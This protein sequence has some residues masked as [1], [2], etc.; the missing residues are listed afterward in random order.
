M[1]LSDIFK[2]ITCISMYC[3]ICIPHVQ[4]QITPDK[5]LPNNSAVISDGN[6]LTING[7]TTAGTNLF[8]SFREFSLLKNQTAIFNNS[9]VTNILT[10][11]TGNEISNI[12]GLIQVNDNANLFLLNPAGIIFG[13][14]AKLNIGGSF[15]ASTA[16]SIKFAD[17]NEFSAINPQ[18][19]SLLTISVPIGLQFGVNPGKIINQ[20]Q[21]VSSF[22]LPALDPRIPISANVGLQV[23]PG[24]TLAFVGGDILLEGGNLT[25]G[26]GQIVVVSLKSE[27]FVGLNLSPQGLSLNYSDTQNLGEVQLFNALINTTGTG[28][29][30]VDI[31]SGNL[32]LD[33]SRILALT[34]ADIDGKSVDIH[35]K[36]LHLR[37]GSQISTLT[38]GEGKGGNLNIQATDSAQ[39]NGIGFE[40]FQ[41]A[42]GVYIASGLL[43]PFDPTIVLMTG[44]SGAGNAGNLNIDTANFLMSEGA[45]ILSGTL[46]A[47]KSGNL[48]IRA[49]NFEVVGAG[50]NAGSYGG[51]TGKGGD[52][53]INTERFLLRDGGAIG[54]ETRT[55]QASGNI[56]IQGT[57]SVEMLNSLSEAVLATI[58]VSSTSGGNGQ[59]GGINID[60]KRFVI[61]GG[62][63]INSDSGATV[64]PGQRI[65]VGGKGGDITI[66]ASESVDVRG[67]SGIVLSGNRFS[68]VIASQTLTPSSGGDIQIFT[69]TL[70]V[71]D[72]GA[73]STASLLGLGDAGNI[74][75]IANQVEVFGSAF[76][77]QF[78]SR[79]DAS[80]GSR[81]DFPRE[82]LTGNGGSL[83]LNV[84]QLIVKDGAVINVENL[85]LG[86]AGNINIVA[87]TI[88]LQNK[89]A[90]N[91][92]TGSGAGGN[93]N[94][95][96][97]NLLLR[98]QSRIATDAGSSV[99]GN[100]KINT[101]NLVAVENS[102][103]TAN[104]TDS[105]GGN[106][107]VNTTGIIGTTFREQLSADSDITATGKTSELR[108]N[109]EINTP[110][111]NPNGAT[112][113]LPSNLV[114]RANQIA[115]TCSS[116]ARTNSFITAGRGGVSPTPREV[117]NINSS[118][119]DWR[120]GKR[121]G[122]KTEPQSD[123]N[124]VSPSQPPHLI[125]AAT[126]VV[127]VDGN[128]ALI[129]NKNTRLN[130]IN[131]NTQTCKI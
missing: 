112:V 53:H 78:I 36:Q 109:V 52:I 94:L 100:I 33:N 119:M 15:I 13:A 47:G 65:T 2:R 123:S 11:V 103:I 89:G 124:T 80:V 62:A 17:G 29:G 117:V 67:F 128:V 102:D 5:T 68:T 130:T 129:A 118:W 38:L 96:A 64:A 54:S 9:P 45:V 19:P 28:G 6:I 40:K 18:T 39:I 104:S 111:I 60:T 82:K 20:S 58:I 48:T 61:A 125:E 76:N 110:N 116:Q 75:V 27:G 23:Q 37:E 26:T 30:K 50:I 122:V 16:N 34:L 77:G 72:G 79:I 59:A 131:Q 99:G 95:L 44:T 91:A 4:A 55:N 10:R 84:K 31:R 21:A 92:S 12:D 14:N 25:A 7:G 63:S 71:R 46:G 49:N 108:G 126:W 101:E 114:D 70:T 22:P 97:N 86:R 8:H 81:G 3:F 115:Q 113:E 35:T 42:L 106:I 120:V 51:S 87:D 90:I 1:H 85:G 56:F 105:R 24:Q 43:S 107:N 83:N 57:E 98:E 74:K 41:Q 127:G 32:T 66:R 93:I 73:I 69:P 88:R 121:N